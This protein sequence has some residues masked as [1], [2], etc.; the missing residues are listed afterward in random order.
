MLSIYK[1]KVE[2]KTTVNILPCRIN[3]DGPSKVTKRYWTPRDEEDGR[4][5]HF[6]GRRLKAR[7]AKLPDRYDG[8]ILQM[9]SKFLPAVPLETAES[10]DDEE[11]EVAEPV[12]IVEQVSSFEDI[13]V[14]GH[15]VQ[16]NSEDPFVKGLTE[17]IGLAEA[18]HTHKPAINS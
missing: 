2:D 12:K 4:I 8:L 13:L 11:P 9:T 16:P 5:V 18:I 7:K 17:W 6:R 1:S 3:Q 15:D 10:E 14:W